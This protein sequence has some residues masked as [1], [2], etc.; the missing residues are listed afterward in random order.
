MH[1]L[2]KCT[3]VFVDIHPEFLTI[4]ETKIEA[5][6]TEKTT[7]ILATHV[8]GNPCNVEEI[9]VIANK[10]NLNVIYDAAHCFGVKYKNQ[11]I[12]NFGDV[13]TCSFHATKIFHTGEG[14][15]IFA[16]MKKHILKLIIVITSDIK[17]QKNIMVLVLMQ[18]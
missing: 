2:G 17:V 6:I 18:K 5:A 8:Y 10:Y 1:C 11:S 12:F 3:P 4:D 13:S 16:V 15:A 14:G 7:A 9:K